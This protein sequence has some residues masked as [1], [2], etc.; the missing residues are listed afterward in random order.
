MNTFKIIKNLLNTNLVIASIP[1]A[2]AS[3]GKYMGIHNAKQIPYKTL[4]NTIKKDTASVISQKNMQFNDQ[5]SY[6]NMSSPSV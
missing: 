1:A 5:T 3:L 4:E 6:Q 2:T